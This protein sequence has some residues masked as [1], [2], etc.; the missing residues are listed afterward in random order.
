MTQPQHPKLTVVAHEVRTAGGMERA[1]FEVISGL[2]E[3][4]WEVHL[5]A[6]VCEL[7]RHSRLRWTRIRTPGRPFA[8]AYP[9]FA[10]VAS[11]VLS[12]VRRHSL[13]V[14]LGA[15]V[16]N[17]VDLMTVQ[18][19]H[20]GFAAHRSRRAQRLSAARRINDTI[21]GRMSLG[22]ERWCMRRGRVSQ[23]TAVSSLVADEIGRY[24]PGVAPITVIPNGADPAHFRPDADRRRRV[25]A[26]LGIADDELVALFVG[27]DWQ[28]KGL[29]IAIEA[30]A[31]ARWTLL[32]VGAGHAGQHAGVIRRSGVKVHFVG[33]SDDP[34]G[35][36]SSADAF[37]LP[38]SY[39]GFALVTVEAA[40]SGLPLLVTEATG[41]AGLAGAG[42]GRVLA[43]DVGAFAAALRELSQDPEQRAR[44]G[45]HARVAARALA[46]PDI[47][48]RYERVYAAE[49]SARQ[50]TSTPGDGYV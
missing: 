13:V 12:G 23:F 18:F 26:E 21:A 15:I 38:S 14:T 37:L 5:L 47:V 22:M 8:L 35:F 49:L 28:R 40:A 39:E 41:A 50:A 24:F 7:P 46:W 4:G 10:L 6:R 44:M 29:P 27:G 9:A 16:F 19:C 32:V 17:R 3:R 1:Q 2:L 11:A 43:R 36:Y 30:V 42:G 20:H 34:A 33:V 45:G 25:R 31:Q 48:A